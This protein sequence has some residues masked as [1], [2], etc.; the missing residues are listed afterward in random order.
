ME[1]T[2]LQATLVFHVVQEISYR[3][4]PTSMAFME[5]IAMA[6]I[7]MATLVYQILCLLAEIPSTLERVSS[8]K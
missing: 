6:T 7:A 3:E 8:T 4:V 2:S 5:T 1:M